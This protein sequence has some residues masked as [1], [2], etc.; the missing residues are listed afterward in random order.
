MSSLD[1]ETEQI[2]PVE[3]WCTGTD[4]HVR[5]QDGREIATP[6]WWHP[7]VSALDD[8]QRNTIELTHS[9]LWWDAADEGI[10]IKSMFMG[11]KSPGAKEPAEA[12]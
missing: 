1:F 10:S 3:A 11:W 7:F 12:A 2:R 9:G 6:L 8:R 5:L 4:I